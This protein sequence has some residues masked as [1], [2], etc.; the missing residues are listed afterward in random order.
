MQ[1]LTVRRKAVII[2]SYLPQ[3]SSTHI[4]TLL[5]YKLNFRITNSFAP[6]KLIA[7]M[8]NSRGTFIGCAA[9]RLPCRV[10]VLYKYMRSVIVRES[11]VAATIER[12]SARGRGIVFTCAISSSIPKSFLRLARPRLRRTSSHKRRRGARARARAVNYIPENLISQGCNSCPREN[13]TTLGD[14]FAEFEEINIKRV[15]KSPSLDE[16]IL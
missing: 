5:L 9:P 2:A 7:E 13:A 3:Q 15:A 14:R 8:S 1:L 12:D 11:I 16:Y 10:R 4:P 6:C